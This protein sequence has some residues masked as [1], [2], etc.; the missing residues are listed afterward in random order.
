MT[1]EPRFVVLAIPRESIT[2]SSAG[3]STLLHERR[4]LLQN[5]R[6]LTSSN[7]FIEIQYLKLIVIGQVT[8]MCNAI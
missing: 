8:L 6:L 5:E 2:A 7:V 4:G 3:R 1:F